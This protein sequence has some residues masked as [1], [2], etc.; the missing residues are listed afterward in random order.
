M[1]Q[2]S[3]REQ[4]FTA[5]NMSQALRL[6]GEQLGPDAIL[7]SSR[8]VSEGVEVIGLPSGVEP[9]T[10]NFQALHSDRR[11]SDRRR[12]S[13]EQPVDASKLAATQASDRASEDK[14]S[15]ENTAV[16]EE[17]TKSSR[18]IGTSSQGVSLPS[19]QSYNTASSEAGNSSPAGSAASR[20]AKSIG[21]FNNPVGDAKAFESLQTELQQVRQMLESKLAQIAPTESELPNPVQ[22]L[23]INRMLQM[24][25]PLTI[26]KTLV[27]NLSLKAAVDSTTASKKEGKSVDPT[28]KVDPAW[29]QCLSRLEAM[30]PVAGS[31]VVAA[32]GIFAL[33]GPSGAGKSSAIAKLAARW[34]LEYSAADVAIIEYDQRATGGQSRLDSFSNITKVPVFIVDENH[35]LDERIKQCARRRLILIDTAGLSD[36]NVKAET[37]LQQLVD[38][39]TP[40]KSLLVLPAT[41]ESRWLSRTVLE[42]RRQNCVGCILSHVDQSP[43]LGE[44]LTVLMKQRLTVN[45]LSSG[46]LLPKYIE[47]AR[48]QS[49]L[50]RLVKGSAVSGRD[51]D[52]IVPTLNIHVEDAT[53]L[54]TS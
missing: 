24:G 51:E 54:A 25:L 53:A 40:I 6:L 14:V 31:D 9:S 34:V 36:E 17:K 3:P 22:Y 12:V 52:V 21:E 18:S 26:A 27:Q 29:Q 30:L 48:S 8:K 5:S 33:V 50:E 19:D 28:S 11:S 32:G 44:V 39:A 47:L 23:F 38:L 45:Y 2:P 4:R 49:V 42:Y 1:Q 35:S 43:S 15:I 10:D 13:R 46:V 20:L 7:L 16:T 37:Q 41:G